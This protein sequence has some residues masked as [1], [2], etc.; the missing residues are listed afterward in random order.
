MDSAGKYERLALRGAWRRFDLSRGARMRDLENR[1]RALEEKVGDLNLERDAVHLAAELASLQ[2]DLDDDTR[3]ALILVTIVSLAALA[4]GSTRFPIAGDTSQGPLREMLAT[5]LDVND[6]EC[7]RARGLID[8]LISNDRAPRVIGR[9]DGDRLPL[10]FFDP[11]IAHQR[12]RALELRLVSSIASLLKHDRPFAEARIQG[13]IA[14]VMERP[15]I[16]GSREIAFSTEQVSA[17]RNAV[18]SPL[19]LISGGPGTGKTSIVVGILRVLTRLGVDAGE[20]ALAAPT[21]RAAFRMREAVAGWLTRIARPSKEDEQLRSA[22]PEA[23]TVHRLLG[24]SPE[25][26]VFLHHRNNPIAAK[27]VIVD[28]AS[29]LDLSLM[30]RLVGALAGDARIVIL[31]DADQLPSVS[32]GAA[33]RDLLPSGGTHPL[34]ASSVR[35]THNYRTEAGD[36]AGGAI[37]EACA[38]INA[39]DVNAI[40]ATHGPLKHRAKA[41]DV[42][43]A[44]VELLSAQASE[45]DGF[46]EQWARRRAAGNADF[47][48]QATRD[49]TIAGGMPAESDRADLARLF[50]CTSR[51]RILCVTRVGDF[52]SDAINARMRLRAGAPRSQPLAA[53]EPVIVVRND[54]YRGLFNGDQGVIVNSV[55]ADGRRS[56][57]AIFVRGDEFAAF[58]IDT[59]RD[60]LEPGYATTVHKAQGSEFDIAALMLPDRDLPLLTRELLYTAVSRCR[61]GVVIIGDPSMLS[62]GISRK[63]DRYSG[64]ADELAKRVTPLPSKQLA[65]DLGSPPPARKKRNQ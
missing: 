55:D 25:R 18:T 15:A 42:E 10:L 16:L 29:M 4:Q 13:A 60:L 61:R 54:Y 39:G 59:L 44:G 50:D 38:R 52:G 11:F 47:A 34:S 23:A 45:L 5:L 8:D 36:S 33:F 46:L 40:N 2:P 57:A 14:D 51:S 24:Y 63:A 12:S 19:A 20:V 9:T 31:G 65:F 1:L 56:L 64:V 28:E 41:E 22:T 30:E 27:V 26:G 48:L 43:F 32:A 7:E 17:I 62:A 53:G 49:Y 21:G 6:R 35:L 58:R 3:F 37:V